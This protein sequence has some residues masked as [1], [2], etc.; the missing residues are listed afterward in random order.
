M[1]IV[2]TVNSADRIPITVTFTSGVEAVDCKRDK[3]LGAFSVCMIVYSSV[4]M[5]TRTEYYC[6]IINV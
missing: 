6:N 1:T 4:Y 3:S 5:C 2:I